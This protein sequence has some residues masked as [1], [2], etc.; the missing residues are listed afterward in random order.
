MPPDKVSGFWFP[1]ADL[2]NCRL[3]AFSK[4]KIFGR[5]YNSDYRPLKVLGKVTDKLLI[6]FPEVY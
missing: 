3:S 1:V 2:K 6:I 5:D 4:N